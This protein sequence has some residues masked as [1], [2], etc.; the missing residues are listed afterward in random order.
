MGVCLIC[1]SC[2]RNAHVCLLHLIICT[3][4]NTNLNPRP[5][6]TW[7]TQLMIKKSASCLFIWRTRAKQCSAL[8]LLSFTCC[9]SWCRFVWGKYYKS[10]SLVRL[11]SW[12]NCHAVSDVGLMK[13]RLVPADKGNTT[14]VFTTFVQRHPRKCSRNFH[15]K[16]YKTPLGLNGLS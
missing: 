8:L 11:L 10:A 2:F 14:H 7:A 9:P 5:L 3:Y 12:T 15:H 13:H 6:G 16:S 4:L 1:S